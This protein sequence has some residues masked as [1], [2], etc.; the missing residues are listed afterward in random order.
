MGKCMSKFT[1]IATQQDNI[2][3]LVEG[4]SEVEFNT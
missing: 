1:A 3:F 4:V 2:P